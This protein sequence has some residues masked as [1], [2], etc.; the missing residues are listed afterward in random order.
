MQT[1]RENWKWGENQVLS[2]VLLH[3]WVYKLPYWTL[4]PSS[5]LLPAPHRQTP[6][7][8]KRSIRRRL[9]F[10]VQYPN[11]HVRPRFDYRSLGEICYRTTAF[12]LYLISDFAG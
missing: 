8:F 9:P 6:I 7:L 5:S 11:T 1:V 2:A 3:L 4:N 10:G 12:K